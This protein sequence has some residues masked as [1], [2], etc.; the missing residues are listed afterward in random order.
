MISEDDEIFGEWRSIRHVV[1]EID[2]D[3]KE[4]IKDVWKKCSGGTKEEEGDEATRS[5]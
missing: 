3:I 1:Q 2:D 4:N 5:E